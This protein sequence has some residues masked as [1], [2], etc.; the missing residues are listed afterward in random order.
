MKLEDA[1]V[2][3]IGTRV[4]GFTQGVNLFHSHMPAQITDGTLILTRVPI[5]PDA[6]NGMRKGTFQVIVRGTDLVAAHD[7]ASAIAKALRGEGA[8]AGDVKF[9]FIFP[10]NEP[11]VFPRTEGSLFEASVNFQFAAHWE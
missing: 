10:E 2:A 4:A 8:V 6:Y 5:Y 1:V 9:L 3:L 11:L 7:K